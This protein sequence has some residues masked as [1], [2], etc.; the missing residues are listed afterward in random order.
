MLHFIR[1]LPPEGVVRRMGR[2]WED[3]MI[4]GE[5][6]KMRDDRMQTGF[7]SGCVTSV[8]VSTDRFLQNSAQSVVYL[9]MV[10]IGA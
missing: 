1:S 7:P 5:T 6:E 2:I 10:Y 4:D 8:C 9:L 3:T